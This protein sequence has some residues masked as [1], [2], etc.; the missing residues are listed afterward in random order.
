MNNL[1]KEYLNSQGNLLQNITVGPLNDMQEKVLQFGEGNFLR[2][3]VDWMINELNKANLFNGK[4]VV[5]QPL[6]NGMI[7]VLKQQDCLYT[8][9]M[10]G[11]NS[12]E[13]VNKKEIITSISRAINPYTE[14][15]NFLHTALQPELRFIFSNTTEAGIAYVKSEYPI[16]ECPASFPAKVTAFLYERYKIFNGNKEKGM[17]IIPCELIENNGAELKK[18]ILKHSVDWKLE[19]EF[20]EWI[21][22]SNYFFNTLVDRIVPGYPHDEIS[23]LTNGLGYEDKLLNAAE[24]FHLWVIEGDDKF[25]E[26]LPFHKV[27]LN[28]LWVKDQRPYRNLK[29]HILNGG[30]TMF[31]IPA[32]LAGKTTVRESMEDEIVNAFIE[33]GMTEEILPTLDFPEEEKLEYYNNIIER[34]KNPF[35][36]HNLQSITLNSVSKFKVRVLP[37]LLKYYKLKNE[38]PKSLVLSLAALIYYYKTNISNSTN[39]S[40]VVSDDNFIIEFFRNK[41]DEFGNDSKSI[42][43]SVLSNIHFWDINLFTIPG[44]SQLVIEYYNKIETAGMNSVLAEF[45]SVKK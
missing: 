9:L 26:E 4:V 44:L 3:F 35:I 2:G 41:S 17:I 38:L 40:T 30:H 36:K 45:H 13:E 33:K 11:I 39:G 20:V 1:N 18:C 7:D 24:I 23:V 12:G 27:G 29:V 8:L 19:N 22:N 15:K 32:L 5:V 16:D 43:E 25:K 37:S 10:R 21:N 28:V 42:C 6:Q 31:T 14:W 34:F